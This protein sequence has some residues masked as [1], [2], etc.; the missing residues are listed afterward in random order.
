MIINNKVLHLKYR[1]SLGV[2]F[3]ERGPVSASKVFF[4][5][6]QWDEKMCLGILCLTL[7][8]C[9][10]VTL[11]LFFPVVYQIRFTRSLPDIS[12]MSS[13]LLHCQLA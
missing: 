6:V 5:S 9:A 12:G 7:R 3:F 8:A 10:S 4:G 11:K 13:I 2:F 1:E